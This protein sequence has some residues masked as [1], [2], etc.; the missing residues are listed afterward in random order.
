MDYSSYYR[1]IKNVF[2]ADQCETLFPSGP[3]IAAQILSASANANVLEH[4]GAGS[5]AD[6]GSLPF[7][8]RCEY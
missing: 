6:L 8:S 5:I 4:I 2:A 3:V 1:R 7:K